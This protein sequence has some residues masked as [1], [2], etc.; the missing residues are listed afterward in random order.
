MSEVAS[1]S[2]G[3][4]TS[5][6]PLSQWTD[7]E[8]TT[9]LVALGSPAFPVTP[10]TRPFLEKRVAK[11]LK[12]HQQQEQA[13][14]IHKDADVSGASSQTEEASEDPLAVTGSQGVESTAQDGKFY[15]VVVGGEGTSVQS[16]LSPYYTNK[17]EVLRAV[18]SV[19]GAR[20]KKFSTRA[21]AEA[22]CSS[23]VDSSS[24]QTTPGP[25]VEGRSPATEPSS[26]EKKPNL[27]P[28]LKTAELTNFRRLIEAGDLTGFTRE[29]WTNPR[30]LI[31]CY[32]DAPEIL[33]VG[34]RYN[35]LHCAVK[36]GRLE[37]CQELLSILGNEEFWKLV[38]PND[39]PETVHQ[40]RAHLVDLYL[41]MQ[42]KMVRLPRLKP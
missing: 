35:A 16:S 10:S 25:S 29:V 32:G 34:F 33:Q 41:N 19:P 5:D 12:K 30:Y 8:L 39:S 1:E 40:R 14:V 20:F 31:N 13:S 2:Q 6:K 21:S 3:L 18:R 26:V 9:I 7:D 22:F 24:R 23:P 36:A 42:D 11:L 15:C 17:S 28:S 27:F 37:I 38:Y 4:Q